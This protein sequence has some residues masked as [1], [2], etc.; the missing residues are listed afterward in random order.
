MKKYVGI[1]KFYF[2]GNKTVNF[3]IVQMFN[4]IMGYLAS[5]IFYSKHM[6]AYTS[7]TFYSIDIFNFR[8]G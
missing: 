2:L 5:I 7:G 4:S 6:R 8:N 3:Y 1:Q